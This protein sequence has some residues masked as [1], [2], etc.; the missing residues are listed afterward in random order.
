MR[1]IYDR[2]KEQKIKHFEFAAFLNDK[3]QECGGNSNE[4]KHNT[5][6]HPWLGEQI[7]LNLHFHQKYFNR[8]SGQ[9]I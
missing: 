7:N 2:D 4:K 6:A 8:G 1:V 5:V 9:P 3:L